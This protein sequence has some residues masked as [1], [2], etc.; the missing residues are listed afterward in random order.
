M[1]YPP[2]PSGPGAPGPGQPQGYQPP[3][4]GYP[5]QGY[6]QQQQGYGPAG[7]QG[8]GGAPAKPAAGPVH[9]SGWAAI[10]AGLLTFVAVFL[11]FYSAK[12]DTSGV[13]PQYRDLVAGQLGSGSLAGSADGFHKWWWLPSVLALLITI[14]LALLVVRV[15]ASTVLRPMWLFY[16][17]V[18]VALA[19]IGVV[20][21]TLVGPEI[22]DG[23]VC[24]SK[25]SIPAE[26]EQIGLKVSLGP[27]WGV[28]V[29]LVLA[30]AFAYLTF[31]HARQ[32]GRSATA[33][34]GQTGYGQGGYGQGGYGQQQWGG[35]Q[36]A[37]AQQQWGQ[38]APG[39]QQWGGQQQAPGQQQWG[40]QQGHA[41]GTPQQ[42]QQ[43]QY[44]QPPAGPG[45]QGGQ[46]QP[47][48]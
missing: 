16:G 47:W 42:G 28:W 14:A 18:V 1:T 11:P 46:G 48:S 9:W 4:G 37:P 36:Q 35:Q 19:A 2:N 5:P 27:G 22:C 26:V 23:G 20:I 7:Q 41:P 25:D 38:Q 31:E 45:A 13:N 34:H 30:L 33:G 40:G 29:L 12:L 3:Q 10:A 32:S 39:Q 6:P 24:V 44:G 43:G 15:L 8:W 17:A 21:H